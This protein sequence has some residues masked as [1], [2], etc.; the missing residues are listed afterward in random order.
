M[1]NNISQ[2]T[3]KKNPQF[4]PPFFLKLLVMSNEP[5]H[6]GIFL[7]Y[8]AFS[9]CKY[10]KLKK[11]KKNRSPSIIIVKKCNYIQEENC[12]IQSNSRLLFL[13]IASNNF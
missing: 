3:A 11:N 4:D 1:P 2:S 9:L 7:L 10:P 8:L 6:W 12:I 5:N 13:I